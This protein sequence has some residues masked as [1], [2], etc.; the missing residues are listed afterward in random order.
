MKKN[1][2]PRI[3]VLFAL[4]GLTLV[5][6]G[7]AAISFQNATKAHQHTQYMK[8]TRSYE[9]QQPMMTDVVLPAET[10]VLSTPTIVKTETAAATKPPLTPTLS[11]W[12][13][14][15]KQVAT[16][17]SR[18]ERGSDGHVGLTTAL[19]ETEPNE[20]WCSNLLI[21]IQDFNY[22]KDTASSEAIQ[23]LTK[24]QNCQ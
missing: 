11:P 2:K 19:A 14:V 4:A 21:A 8:M 15:Q 24:A 18:L 6:L 1:N 3:V 13:Q 10:A 5:F 16:L 7:A 22:L 9:T 23:A 12:E 20:I 17:R